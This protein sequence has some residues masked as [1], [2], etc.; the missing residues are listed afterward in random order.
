M[1]SAAQQTIFKILDRGVGL[2]KGEEMRIFEKFYRA[3]PLV[4]SNIPGL[5]IGLAICKGQV[6]ANASILTAYQRDGG[7]AV[8]E[9]TLGNATQEETSQQQSESKNESPC[10]R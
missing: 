3:E 7:G 1:K 10:S 4:E 5:G 9:L 8:F 6:E 2:P